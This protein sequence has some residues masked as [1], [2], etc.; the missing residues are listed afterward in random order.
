MLIGLLS[1]AD[2]PRA[3]LVFAAALATA[4]VVGIGFHEFCHALVADRLGDP[5]PRA[6]G[7][8]T[9]NPVRHLDPAGTMLLLF[10]GFGWGKPVPV[11]PY[12]LRNGGRT[13]MAVVAAAGPLS[14]LLV[15]ALAGLP[16]RLGLVPLVAW[17]PEPGW[18]AADYLGL[19][20]FFV[21]FINLILALFNFIPVAPLDGFKVALGLLPVDMARSFQRLEPYGIG[22]LMIL[23]ALPFLTGGSVDVL[24]EIMDPA[25]R[26]LFRLLT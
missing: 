13:G 12:R 6:M 3:L 25:R 9:L 10:A 26:E 23:I 20:L 5:T 24:G 18:T 17:L 8:L 14:N 19:F 22:I 7:R 21:I 15:A 4:F 11:N 2:D 1:L 16:I